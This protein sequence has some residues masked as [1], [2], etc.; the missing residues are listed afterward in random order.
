M[1]QTNS[2]AL[3][4][5]VETLRVDKQTRRRRGVEW[6]R[7]HEALSIARKLFHLC[8]KLRQRAAG[9]Q[10]ALEVRE[11]L[12]PTAGDRFNQF[13]LRPV[14]LMQ[15]GELHEALHWLDFHRALRIA[16]GSQ[17]RPELIAPSDDDA[18]L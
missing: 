16:F 18:L 11:N 15:D 14:D 4:V 5:G 12:R 8:R 6:G 3:N 10:Q 7:E 1:R 17:F 13:R 2:Q 9:L